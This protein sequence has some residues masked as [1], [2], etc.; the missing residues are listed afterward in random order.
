MAGAIYGFSPPDTID[1]TDIPFDTGGNSYAYLGTD[2]NGNP[3]IEFY[4]NDNG[5]TY[6]LNI[7]PSQVFPTGA[8]FNLAQDASGNGTDLSVSEPALTFES[9][10]LNYSY[11][12]QPVTVDGVVVGADGVLEVDNGDTVNRTV[13]QSGGEVIGEYYSTINDTFVDGGGLLDLVSASVGSGAIDFGP[14]VDGVGGTLEIDDQ[15]TLAATITG[16]T[17]GDTID[18]TAIPYDPT[19]EM[20]PDGAGGNLW[21]VDENGSQYQLQF[22]PS[23]DF[24]NQT[25][26]LSPD[27]GSGTDITLQQ[28]PIDTAVSIPSGQTVYGA[29]VGSGGSVDVQAAATFNYGVINDGGLVNVQTGGSLGSGIDF[30]SK[31]AR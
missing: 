21:D 19:G 13:V 14:I 15:S 17:V 18:L 10:D 2:P 27:L 4:D 12:G 30:G 25:F 29:L 22:D 5:N 31:V 6:Y 24:L 7:E 28:T 8:T 23:Q 1:L 3:A 20:V 26:V 9:V 11:G 16:F